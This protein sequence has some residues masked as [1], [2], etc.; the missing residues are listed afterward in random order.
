[1]TPRFYRKSRTFDITYE[2]YTLVHVEEFIRDERSG[3]L[4]KK[5]RRTEGCNESNWLLL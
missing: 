1:M 2:S 5:Y 3:V 4:K